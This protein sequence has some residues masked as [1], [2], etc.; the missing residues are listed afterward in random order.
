MTFKKCSIR[1]KLYGYVID[2]NGSEIQDPKVSFL[3][4]LNLFEKEISFE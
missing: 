1:G 2:E 4:K 3:K